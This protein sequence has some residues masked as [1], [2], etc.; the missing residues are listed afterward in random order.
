MMF[1]KYLGVGVVNTLFGFGLIFALMFFGLSPELAN[2]V[3]Y[4]FGVCL[5]YVLNK[6]FTFK[7]KAKNKAQFFKFVASML[8][9]YILNFIALKLLLG[10]EV[11]A[12]LAQ[13][14]AGGVYTISGFLLSKFWSFK[15]KK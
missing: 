14:V 8:I 9:A 7:S 15:D 2:L 5:S 10:L 3:G 6:T 12:Y 11:N 13:V 1:V 4:G